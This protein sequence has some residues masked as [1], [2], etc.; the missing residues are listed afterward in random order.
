MRG[1]GTTAESSKAPNL[2]T[3]VEFTNAISAQHHNT[4]MDTEKFSSKE[5]TID[6][7]TWARPEQ[8]SEVTMP[9]KE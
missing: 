4:L 8:Q 7:S 6:H 2:T 1:I 5:M 3:L 9:Y